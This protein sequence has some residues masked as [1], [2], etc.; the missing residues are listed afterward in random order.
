MTAVWHFTPQ[1]DVYLAASFILAITPGP[2]VVYIV[3]RSA[4]HGRA[5]GVMSVAG[6]AL[7][8]LG[9]VLAASLGLAAIL[10]LSSAAFQAVKYL[11]AAYLLYRNRPILAALKSGV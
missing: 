10:A 4:T 7:G 5:A 2:G 8:N 1:L 11:G 6:V 3:T 9:S